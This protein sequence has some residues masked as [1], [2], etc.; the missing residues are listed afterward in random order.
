MAPRPRRLRAAI[1]AG[2]VGALALTGGSAGLATTAGAA[3]ATVSTDPATDSASRAGVDSARAVV[4]LS[5]EPLAVSPR[6]K[7]A[8]GKKL[9]FSSTATKSERA[10]LSAQRNA[11]KQWLQTVAPKARVTSEYDVAVNAVSVALNGTP[12]ATLRGGPGVVAASYAGVYTPLDDADPDLGLVDAIA[13][14]KSLAGTAVPGANAGA[15][16]RVGIVD[17]GIDA[18]HPCFDGR[19]VPYSYPAFGGSAGDPRFTSPKVVVAKVFN[20]RAKNRGLTAEAVDDHGTHVAGTVACELDTPAVVDGVAIPYRMSGVAPAAQLGN[21]NVFPGDVADARSEDI[22]DALQAAAE[23]GMD[24]VNMSLGG[25]AHGVQDLLTVAVDNLD[26]GANMVVAVANGNSGPGHFTVESP[27][28]AE[29]A[30]SAGAASVGH[31]VGLPLTYAGVTYLTAAGD[32]PIP[33]AAPLSAPLEAALS[34]PGV[35][36]LA[37]APLPAGSLTGSIAVVKR[38]SCTFS[39]K[40]RAAQDAGAVGVVVVNNV[41]GDPTAMAAD[42]TVI[43]AP[44][45]PAVMAGVADEAALRA[46]DGTAT[47]TLG[48]VPAY[49]RTANDS[50]M[51]GFSS[52][53]PTDVD[54][55]VKPDVV[56]P[57][58]NV[59]SSVPAS[60]CALAPCFAFLSGTSMAT[61]HLAGVAAVVRGA[62]PAW[63]PEQVRS[64][65]VNTATQGVLR[66]AT[67]GSPETDV[68]VVG[69]GAASLTSALAATVALGPVS[70]SFG[71][72]PSGSGQTLTKAVTLTNLGASAATYA[73]SVDGGVFSVPAT[74]TVAAGASASVPVTATFPKGAA[75]GDRQATLRV[76]RGATEV[77]HSV[78]YALVK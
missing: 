77:A 68:Q 23:D 21:Y 4:Q 12:L 78:V 71:A 75:P 54:L 38:G 74:V 48:D 11:F 6:T 62:R 66:A 56:A 26:R 52:Q 9:D 25:G 2:A 34:A 30:L 44:T 70:T 51:A 45:I 14:W 22:L 31:F 64:A 28:S 50:V 7:P 39:T 72:V 43:P 20:M 41:A 19:G 49:Q 17:S 18:T 29:R 76:K 40:A 42:D 8:R 53:G 58:V 36:S 37:C 13:A 59:L 67:D 32:L 24:V 1:V 55:R 61:P 46:A 35:L 3:P 63:T 73:L 10:R 16:V 33:T 5:L 69:S 57:G 60:A 27:G 15:G 47:A 65:I